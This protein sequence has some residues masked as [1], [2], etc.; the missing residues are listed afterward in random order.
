MG[1][2]KSAAAVSYSMQKNLNSEK[3]VK[4]SVALSQICKTYVV[5]SFYQITNTSMTC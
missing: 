4:G 1:S 5:L 3:A 2:N